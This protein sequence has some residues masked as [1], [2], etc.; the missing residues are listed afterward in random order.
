[1]IQSPQAAEEA[2]GSRVRYRIQLKRFI[3]CEIGSSAA[4]M[5]VS[6]DLF[7][8]RRSL[9]GNFLREFYALKYEKTGQ[10]V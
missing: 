8:D 3:N 5:Q 2:T 4:L 9:P 7:D 1:M 10:A 6:C